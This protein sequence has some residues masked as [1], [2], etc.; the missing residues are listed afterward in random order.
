M[1][2]K[3]NNRFGIKALMTLYKPKCKDI[4]IALTFSIF[5]II[6]ICML[7]ITPSIELLDTVVSLI[8]NIIPAILGF[9]LSGYALL[10]GF[11]NFNFIAKQKKAGQITLYQKIS[12]VFTVSLLF[13]MILLILGIIFRFAM[14]A[15]LSIDNLKLV[16][17]INYSSIFFLLSFLFYVILLVK[18]LVIVIFN[19]SQLQHF[20]INSNQ[21]KNKEEEQKFN[22]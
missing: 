17:V 20:K 9:V 18:D 11:G 8:L 16:S 10:I 21:E 15:S 2:E 12:S 14:D 1:I 22:L 6:P 7:S 3:T 13:Q 4:L 19:Y 5:T